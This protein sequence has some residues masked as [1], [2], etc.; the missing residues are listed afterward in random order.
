MA[1]TAH[2]DLELHQM[3]V[4]MEFLNRGLEEKEYISSQK[5][6]L[7]GKKVNYFSNL[8]IQYMN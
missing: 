7:L 4:K 2:M 6:F 1:L 8:I 5:D 3:D